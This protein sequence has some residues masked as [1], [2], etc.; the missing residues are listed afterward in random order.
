[1]SALSLKKKF[2]MTSF[3][4]RQRLPRTSGL[5]ASFSFQGALVSLVFLS[6][7]VVY[8]ATLL[9]PCQPA[10]SFA[11]CAAFAAGYRGALSRRR[12]WVYHW[13]LSSVNHFSL[14]L[15]PRV[16][17]LYRCLLA[18]SRQV[19]EFSVFIKR[20]GTQSIPVISKNGLWKKKRPAI[21]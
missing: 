3:A 18:T 11:A 9:L 17:L 5:F 6:G 15:F 21:Q 4:L 12:K 19:S 1:M 10:F 20:Y 14:F 8:Y 7:N 2:L 16:T 13:K